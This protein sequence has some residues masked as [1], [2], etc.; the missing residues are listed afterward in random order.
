M[1]S[2]DYL[3]KEYS[4]KDMRNENEAKVCRIIGNIIDRE[5][6]KNICTCG[7]CLEDIYGISLNQ[8]PPQYRHR[9]SVRLSKGKVQ[10]KDI[11][12]VIVEAI[13]KV[14]KQ[15]KHE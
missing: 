4:L 2:G 3:V 6:Y 15:P 13:E 7:I 9:S 12:D 1:K 11:E 5:E 8:L 10:D 14:R